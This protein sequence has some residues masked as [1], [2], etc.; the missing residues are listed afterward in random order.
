MD[1][2]SG[3]RVAEEEQ[4]DQ[5]NPEHPP[6]GL[7]AAVTVGNPAAQGANDA[8]GQGEQHGNERG[9]FQ[10]KAVFA[11][12]V[13]RQPQRQRHKAAE[14]EVVSDPEPPHPQIHQWGELLAERQLDP[15]FF[16]FF[17][18]G[19][20]ISEEPEHDGHYQHGDGIDLR[21]HPPAIGDHQ[22]RRDEVRDG[23]TGV[24]GAEDAHGRPLP[25]LAEPG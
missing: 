1:S 7:A 5:R 19:I 12:V 6:S 14:Y 4:T 2:H 21:H 11:D 9:G 13:F 8:G 18:L 16:A 20:G 22:Q 10:I 17:G 3:L 15:G 23:G 25:F 24:T